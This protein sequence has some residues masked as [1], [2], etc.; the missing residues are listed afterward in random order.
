MRENRPSGLMRGGCVE[1]GDDNYGLQ[2][3]LPHLP[4]LLNRNDADGKGCCPA[5]ESKESKGAKRERLAR[6]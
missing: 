6:F 2:P 1:S 5:K 3:E 4:T